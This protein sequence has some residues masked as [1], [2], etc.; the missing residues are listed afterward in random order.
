MA[1]RRFITGLPCH[2]EVDNFHLPTPRVPEMGIAVVTTPKQSERSV[3][4]YT[5][6]RELQLISQS[7]GMRHSKNTASVCE[8][9]N[10]FRLYFLT[11]CWLI[12]RYT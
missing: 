8:Q 5:A 10:G 1:C 12:R 6:L 3:K 11:F 2:A 4:F 7:V 9:L